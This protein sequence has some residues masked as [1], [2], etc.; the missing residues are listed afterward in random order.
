MLN[1]DAYAEVTDR[2]VELANDLAWLGSLLDNLEPSADDP[3][4]G[5]SRSHPAVQ[6]EGAIDDEQL[7][8]RLVAITRLAE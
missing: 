1:T 3:Q 5:V 4:Q 2:H 8:V 7:A 6:M